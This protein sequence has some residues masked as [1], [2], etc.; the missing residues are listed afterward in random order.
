M[1][2]KLA[3]VFLIF[4]SFSISA[5][6]IEI[7][8]GGGPTYYKGDLQPTF[9]IFNPSV[10][11]SGFV[12]YNASR[13]FSIK[14]NVMAGFITGNDKRSGNPLNKYRDFKFTNT[15]WDYYGQV[16]YNFLNFRTHNGRYEHKW[17]PYLFGGFGNMQI[18]KKQ[19]SVNDIKSP[20]L[21]KFSPD[22]VLPFGIGYKK[23]MNGK[24]NFGV[25]FST[26]VLM[27]KKNADMFDGF[28]F[29]DGERKSNYSQ[30]NGGVNNFEATTYPNTKQ[31][32]K[33]FTVTA[34]V[35]YLF[36][37]IYCPPGK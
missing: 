4:S 20:A 10:G 1:F 3:L 13:V 7:G 34:S 27:R 36:Y 18:I 6:K 26:L 12:R 5:Q 28:G 17:T 29:V 19:L 21:K 35:S 24:W 22:P 33:Y 8:L 30:T 14:A 25:E 23:I 11:A 32:D 31:P 9:R 2:K 16:E 37:K 15:L